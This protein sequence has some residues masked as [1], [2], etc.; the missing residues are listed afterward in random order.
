M[1]THAALVVDRLVR[2]DPRCE[3]VVPDKTAPLVSV[4][5]PARDAECFLGEALESA[6]AQPVALEL[7]V[8]DDGSRDGT[9]AVA[10][11]F[12]ARD[13]R[14]RVLR[15]ARPRGVVAA[16]NELLAEARGRYVAFLDAD[17][18]YLPGALAER[19]ALLE[20]EPRVV[21]VH[22]SAQIVDEHG[23]RLPDW[24][25]PFERDTVEPGRDAFAELLLANELTTST[26]VARRDALVAA[27]GFVHVGPSSSDWDMWLRLA[28]RGDVAYRA[29]PVARY[30]QHP[31]TISHSATASGERLRCD[32][33]VVRRALSVCTSMRCTDPQW[34]RAAL[35]RRARSA[36]AAKALLHAGDAQTRGERRSALRALALAARARPDLATAGLPRLARAIA[37]GDDYAAFLASNALLDR[38]AGA[39]VG[40]RY[41]DVVADR[42]APDPDW[43]ATLRRIARTVGTVTPPDAV[44]G[45]VTKWDPTLLALS[46]RHGRNF[47]DRASLPTGYPPDDAVAV[48]HLEQQRAQGLSHLVFPHASF[49]WLDHYAGLAE[50][51]RQAGPPV[52]ADD[53]CVIFDLRGH[54]RAAA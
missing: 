46:G 27:G 32:A 8:C 20:R 26:V 22:G 15:L 17:D 25:R 7:L 21:L 10:E 14:V 52:H 37:R 11:S 13:L 31:A 29:A 54:P 33:R 47:P 39:L 18:A 9:G 49:W 50:R 4:C 2:S 44:L 28:L 3:E 36:L 43:E 6:L 51:L 42:A 30:R 41:G 35:A 48:A 45:T 5:V 16:R 53:E 12:A 38:L 19:V 23:R 24:R 34:S 40:T 1:S